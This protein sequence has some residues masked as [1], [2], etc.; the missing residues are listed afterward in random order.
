MTGEKNKFTTQEKLWKL[1]DEQLKT[2]KHDEL[3]LEL[4][5]SEYLERIIPDSPNDY[6]SKERGEQYATLATFPPFHY[7][8]NKKPPVIQT[9][10]PIQNKTG[11]LIGYW[12]IVA[13]YN[14]RMYVE[15]QCG[16]MDEYDW[17]ILDRCYNQPESVIGKYQPQFV[18]VSWSSYT[19]QANKR[20][21]IEVKPTISSFGA[22]IRQINTYRLY[23]DGLIY[24]YTGDR[25]FDDAFESQGIHVIHPI[26]GA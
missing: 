22:T 23:S 14:I 9:E 4:L 16:N 1:D 8:L 7:Y 21:N 20:I 12:D 19:I 17:R 10:V 3:V 15:A 13:A 18:D 25:K 6:L 11:F 2:P 24:L 5:N 26:G